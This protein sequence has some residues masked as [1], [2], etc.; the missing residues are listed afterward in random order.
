[1]TIAAIKRIIDP[2]DIAQIVL[3]HEHFDHTGGVKSLF[4]E[5]EGS[6]KILAHSYASQ[7]I[8]RGESLFASLLGGT[9]PKMPVDI[10][11]SGGETLVIGDDQYNVLSTPGHTPGCI[12]LYN[13]S[14]KRLFSGDTVFA[15]G[16]FGRYD[17]AGGNLRQLKESLRLLHSLDVDAFYPGH[18]AMVEYEGNYH[19]TT[20]MQNIEHL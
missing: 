8:E 15:H 19:I 12:C 14:H 16:S 3:T 4:E 13:D 18:D 1:M 6:A 9:M 10:K 7:K 17:L 11:L 20:S 5:T 2:R